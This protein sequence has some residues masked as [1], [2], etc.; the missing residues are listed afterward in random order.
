M[1]GAEVLLIGLPVRVV[2]AGCRRLRFEWHVFLL[3]SGLVVSV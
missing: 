3:F 2:L 1:D